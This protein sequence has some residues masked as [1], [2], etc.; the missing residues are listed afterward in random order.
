MLWFC[1]DGDKFV[2][3]VPGN[4]RFRWAVGPAGEGHRFSIVRSGVKGLLR[5]R[6]DRRNCSRKK[7][8]IWCFCHLWIMLIHKLVISN[9]SVWN[10]LEVFMLF[11][12]C[13]SLSKYLFKWHIHSQAINMFSLPG[14]C[15]LTACGT[16]WA[17]LM[18]KCCF[19]EIQDSNFSVQSLATLK[20]GQF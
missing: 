17:K 6:D 4:I 7:N 18:L 12:K 16:H 14:K 10:L 20:N 5:H 3:P 11:L 2:I 1:G 8:I 13:S 9:F 15:W 19:H